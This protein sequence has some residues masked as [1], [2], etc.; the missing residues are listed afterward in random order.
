A[1]RLAAA[2]GD[3]RPR[4]SRVLTL[5]GAHDGAE[6]EARRAEEHFSDKGHLPGVR[7]ARALPGAPL[8]VQAGTTTTEKAS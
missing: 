2:A 8:G 7:A 5:L 1:D 3:G 4:R 6:A